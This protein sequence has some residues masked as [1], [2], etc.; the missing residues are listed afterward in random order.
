MK[1][2]LL[3]LLFCVTSS[4]FLKAQDR[5]TKEGSSFFEPHVGYLF[6][7]GTVK[8]QGTDD[9]WQNYLFP[10]SSK[11]Q[12]TQKD[13]DGNYL[14]I[15]AIYGKFITN[16][17]QLGIGIDMDF[18]FNVGNETGKVL[19]VYAN[20]RYNIAAEKD[21][22]Y[23]YGNAGYAPQL[24]DSFHAGFKGGAGLGYSIQGK[25]HAYN[26]S[27][28]YNYQVVRG[29]NQ[30]VFTISSNGT[31]NTLIGVNVKN[32]VISSIPLQFGISF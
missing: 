26:I 23:F 30:E 22:I 3:L 5:G 11:D 20:I 14:N 13:H 17:V 2:K 29:L 32:V 12:A 6:A 25:K 16:D 7:A 21:F 9:P 1:R 24:G 10:E 18:Y 19:P 31:T 15:G 4:F 28:G 8:V 27:L